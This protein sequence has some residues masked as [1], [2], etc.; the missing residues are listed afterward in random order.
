MPTK[1]GIFSR[2]KRTDYLGLCPARV[3]DI[4]LTKDDYLSEKISK[5]PGGNYRSIGD[6]QFEFIGK[7]KF[8]TTSGVMGMTN[9]ANYAKPLSDHSKYYPTKGELVLLIKAPSSEMYDSVGND[10]WYY[11]C[12]INMWK[13]TQSNPGPKFGKN[14]SLYQSPLDLYKET[15]QGIQPAQDTDPTSPLDIIQGKYFVEKNTVKGL[16]A[17]EGDYLL[18]GRWGNSLRMGSTIDNRFIKEKSHKAPWSEE[19][20]LGDPITILSNGL[21]KDPL[22]YQQ[23]SIENDSID[24]PWIPTV[25][26]INADPSSIYLTSTQKISNFKV[27]GVGNPSILAGIQEEKTPTEAL[28]TGTNYME[29]PLLPDD[30]LPLDNEEDAVMY[31]PISQ[32]V[33]ETETETSDLEMFNENEKTPFYVVEKNTD[34]N[35]IKMHHPV[36][37]FESATNHLTAETQELDLEQYIGNNFRL[38]HLISTPKA[39]DINY[40][41]TS[42]NH[43]EALFERENIGFYLEID[44]KGRKTICAKEYVNLPDEKYR[45][46]SKYPQINPLNSVSPYHYDLTD[47]ELVKEAETHVFGNHSNYGINNYPGIDKDITQGEILNN[48]TK[49]F[50]NVIDP[51]MLALPGLQLVSVYRSKA[52]NYVLQ[53]NPPHSEH[54][55]G[56]AA[57]IRFAGNN[58]GLY[59]H[60]YNNLEFKNLSWSYPERRNKSWVH[61]SF[62]EGQNYKKTTL[63][64]QH[65]AF[66][67]IYGGT[68][69]GRHE[70]YQDNIEQAITPP[71]L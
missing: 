48:L 30:I 32:E 51:I 68:R 4:V 65:E 55:Y 56:Y 6:I 23:N 16:L 66:H 28:E 41:F 63:I 3:I 5:I 61:V 40:H 12:N 60:I 14:M 44:N 36:K 9:S 62:I 47:S 67:N 52:L 25:E 50:E 45:I 26:N 15:E 37:L 22:I 70:I 35:N 33:L 2:K 17:Y 18:E 71:N 7:D 31:N 57:D 46:I 20:I 24:S 42:E 54:I 1:K 58:E 21:P 13:N 38:K 8:S 53:G 10:H 49:L 11:L 29:T 27:A 64:S 39:L 43:L 34:V 69:R 59:N 19:G